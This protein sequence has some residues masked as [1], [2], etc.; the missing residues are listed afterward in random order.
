MDLSIGIGEKLRKAR[1]EKGI[2]FDDVVKDT[3]IRTRY[4]QALEEENWDVFPGNVYLKGFLRTYSNYLGLDENEYLEQINGI[5]KQEPELLKMPQKIELPGRPRRKIGIIYGIIAILLL[6]GI[7]YSY[8]NFFNKPNTLPPQVPPG[9]VGSNTPDQSENP[10][11]NLPANGGQQDPGQNQV[12]PAAE[13]Q[14]TAISLRL[15]AVEGR[16]WVQVKN[17]TS[18]IYEGTLQKGEEKVFN[19]LQR[20][21]FTLGNSGGVRVYLNEEDYGILGKIGDVVYKKYALQNNQIVDL[22]S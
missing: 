12:P 2:T 15:Q 8:T 13:Q 5:V 18:I 22:S 16:C 11:D 20:V 17:E 9:Q 7:Q 6:L 14:Y 3:K 4:L 19:D 21:D 10:D 1:L